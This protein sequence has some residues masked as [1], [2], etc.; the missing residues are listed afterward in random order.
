MGESRELFNEVAQLRDQVDDMNRSVSA[1]T[2]QSGLFEKILEAMGK[3]EILANIFLQ[4]DGTRTQQGIISAMAAS[5]LQAVSQTTVSRKIDL[6]VHD[7]DL[8][9][10]TNRSSTGI[11]YVHTSLARALKVK[12]ALEKGQHKPKRPG[13]SKGK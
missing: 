7:W 5:G 12:R 3:D 4:V 2:R 8:V 6:L 9:R 13:A 10:P 1:L 11:I